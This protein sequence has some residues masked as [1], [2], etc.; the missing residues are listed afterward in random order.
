MWL[1]ELENDTPQ[2][3]MK[4]I[5]LASDI[6]LQSRKKETSL[7]DAFRGALPKAFENVCE[8]CTTQEKEQLKRILN[9]WLERGAF[10]QPFISQLDSLLTR[11]EEGCL[12]CGPSDPQTSLSCRSSRTIPP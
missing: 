11:G 5:F 9:I 7:T 8:R 3:K 6:I 2:K 10:A 1:S 4:Y 12:G